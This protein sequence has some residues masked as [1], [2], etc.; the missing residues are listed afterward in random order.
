[1]SS[2]LVFANLVKFEEALVHMFEMDVDITVSQ[3]PSQ[4]VVLVL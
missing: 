2:V 1:M 4:S 3:L